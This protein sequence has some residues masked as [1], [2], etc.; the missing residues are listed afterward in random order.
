[1]ELCNS[2]LF[3]FFPVFL[4]CYLVESDN[5]FFYLILKV[6][7]RTDKIKANQVLVYIYCFL[8]DGKAERIL[9]RPL[10]NILINQILF[11]PLQPNT[12]KAASV[13]S[14]YYY[15]VFTSSFLDFEVHK[16]NL[17]LAWIWHSSRR[18]WLR[19]QKIILHYKNLW[20]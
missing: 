10:I 17:N 20:S 18:H 3:L 1:M 14:R 7:F 12:V 6:S 5:Y 19:M 8:L 2:L 11:C 15:S 9:I 13:F 16:Y 4:S